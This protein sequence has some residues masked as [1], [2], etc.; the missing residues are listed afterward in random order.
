VVFPAFQ[1]LDVFGPLDFLNVISFTKKLDLAVI[2]ST[3]DPV[4][5]SPLVNQ[6][7]SGSNFGQSINPTHTFANPPKDLEVLIVPGGLGTR[8]PAPALQDAIQYINQTYPS[9]K[10]IISVCTGASLIA[11]AGVLEGKHATTNKRSWAFSSSFGGP[12]IH[13]VPIARWVQD[14]NV[15]ST[16]GIAAGM[17]GMLGFIEYIYGTE[18]AQESANTGEYQWHSDPSWDPYSKIWNVPGSNA[19]QLAVSHWGISGLYTGH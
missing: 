3:L 8:A 12:N 9:L 18:F 17:D 14:G 11:R 10:Y 7:K 13:W 15:W 19:T 6:T 16:S 4:S 1:A 2:A 5:T